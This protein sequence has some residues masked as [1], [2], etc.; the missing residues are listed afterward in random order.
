MPVRLDGPP[1]HCSLTHF[2][3]H[4]P[5]PHLRAT[6]GEL[7]GYWVGTVHDSQA[8]RTSIC[9]FHPGARLAEGP[10]ATLPLRHHIPWGIHADFFHGLG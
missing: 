6:A 1:L 4:P 10:I 2:H 9:I 8:Q 3:V 5:C 7:D